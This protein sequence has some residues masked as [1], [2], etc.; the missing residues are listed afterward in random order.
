VDGVTKKLSVWYRT[1]VAQPHTAGA[2]LAV[3]NIFSSLKLGSE[4]GQ[5]ENVKPPCMLTSGRAEIRAQEGKSS[6]LMCKRS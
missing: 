5:A 3:S 6:L 1:P 4:G 2:I